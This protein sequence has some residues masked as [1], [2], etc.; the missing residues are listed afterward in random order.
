M[1]ISQHYVIN[2]KRRPEKLYGWLGAQS[3]MG[4]DFSKLTVVEA[5]DAAAWH[6]W[7]DFF[8]EFFAY[9]HENGID[10]SGLLASRKNNTHAHYGHTF[11]GMTRLAIFLETEKHENDTDYFMMW[12][13]DMCLKVP[14]ED[15]LACDLPGDATMVGLHDHYGDSLRHPSKEFRVNPKGLRVPQ[16]FLFNKKGASTILDFYRETKDILDLEH[17][18]EK[19][20]DLPGMYISVK[21]YTH[22]MFFKHFFSD[23]MDASRIKRKI[24]LRKEDVIEWK[25]KSLAIELSSTPKTTKVVMMTGTFDLFHAGHAKVIEEA[26]KLGDELYIGIGSDERVRLRKG[27]ARPVIPAAAAA[28]NTSSK[29]TCHRCC[30]YPIYTGYRWRF[31]A[32]RYPVA[33]RTVEPSYMG[34]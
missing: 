21:N 32:K 11:L 34:R 8:T 25:T 31:I 17:L 24:E 22:P 12:E 7:G 20:P 4:F 9:F 28:G 18:I 27:N 23:L 10:Y 16:A 3:Q 13:D 5:F 19:R 29:Q 30:S 26:S 14:Y 33:D 6:T 15:L 2:L 1:N